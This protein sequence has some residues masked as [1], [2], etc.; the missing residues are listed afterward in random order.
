[1]LTGL[2][3]SSLQDLADSGRPFV[4][5]SNG[6]TRTYLDKCERPIIR[7]LAPRVVYTDDDMGG[8]QAELFSGFA[9]VIQYL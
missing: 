2:L 4:A 9:F 1:M 3:H 5:N 6:A 8:E 7:Q